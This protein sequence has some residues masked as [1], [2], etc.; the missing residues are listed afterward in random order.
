MTDTHTGTLES[1]GAGT[2]VI[3]GILY[4]VQDSVS[5]FVAWRKDGE[6]VDFSYTEGEGGR[7]LKYITKSSTRAPPKEQQEKPPESVLVK[8]IQVN[9]VALKCRRVTDDPAKAGLITAKVNPGEYGKLTKAGV[10]EGDEILVIFDN[11]GYFNLPENFRVSAS[12]CTPTSVVKGTTNPAPTKE[13]PPLSTAQPPQAAPE[14]AT[15]RPVSSQPAP[16]SNGNDKEPWLRYI[17]TLNT[18][19]AILEGVWQPDPMKPQAENI[20][21]KI[22]WVI[23]ISAGLRARYEKNGGKA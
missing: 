4:K 16:G 15:A 22:E 18:A 7:L 23:S 9:E 12:N 21:N 13:T 10:K 11:K 2:V 14:K 5:K 6:V 19:T 3:D 20:A 17:S 1:R 8:V